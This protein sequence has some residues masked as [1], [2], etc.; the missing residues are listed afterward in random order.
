MMVINFEKVSITGFNGYKC[1]ALV[2]DSQFVAAS[3]IDTHTHT[4]Y[5]NGI[6]FQKVTNWQLKIVLLMQSRFAR[7]DAFLKYSDRGIF[8]KAIS[9][10]EMENNGAKNV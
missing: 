10:F 8:V 1:A 6:A 9:F 3:A 5:G 7:I 2:I 4:R